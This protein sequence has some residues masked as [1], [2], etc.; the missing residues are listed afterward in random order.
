MIVTFT[1]E[2]GSSLELPWP[3]AMSLLISCSLDGWE[4]W[5]KG[6]VN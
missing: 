2:D 1:F 6:E 3:A 4:C 5:A